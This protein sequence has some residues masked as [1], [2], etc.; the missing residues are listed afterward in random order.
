MIWL[1]IPI[2]LIILLVW[3]F[4]RT[5]KFIIKILSIIF[6]IFV[7]VLSIGGF[8][9]QNILKETSQIKEILS[10][11]DK[12]LYLY[13]KDNA[14]VFG[15]KDLNSD[16]TFKLTQGEVLVIKEAFSRKD[17]NAMKGNYSLLVVVNIDWL[18]DVVPDDTEFK[19]E[20]D[21]SERIRIL[22]S[23][24]A[25]DE[26]RILFE[27][28]EFINDEQVKVMVLKGM[29]GAAMRS[30]GNSGITTAMQRGDFLIYP[31]PQQFE[32]LAYLPDSL[33]G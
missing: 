28:D 30:A 4:V 9:V 21:K 19:G 8:F 15:V 16:E 12:V 3:W 7:I 2:I 5:T 24:N 18:D 33:H 20:L 6:V 32:T 31:L 13:D 11:A 14:F 26:F 17:Y 22:R 25:L 1:I 23:T 10:N 29:V 27:G